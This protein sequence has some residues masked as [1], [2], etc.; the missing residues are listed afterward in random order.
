[1]SAKLSFYPVGN[2]DMALITLDNGQNILIDVNIRAA[3]DGEDEDVHDVAQDLKDRLP[4]DDDDRP[5]VD[6]FLISHP[7]VDHVSGLRNHFHLGPPDEYPDDDGEDRILIREMWSSPIIFRRASS[8]H[9]LGDD[10]KAWA[11]EAR[12]RVALFR[13]EGL[14]GTGDGDRIL[15]LGKDRDG[16]TDGI[17]EIVKLQDELVTA[18]NREEAGQF[19]ARLLAPIYVDPDQEDADKLIELLSKNNSSVI[20]RFSINA[21]GKKDACRFLSGGDAGVEIWDRLWRRHKGKNEDWFSYDVMETPHHCSWRT[22]SHDRWSE[23][24]EDVKVSKDARNALSQTRDGAHIVAS[25]NPIKKEEPNP[26]HERAKREYVS[27][28]AS[29]RFTCT[30]EYWEK[31]SRPIEFSI[32]HAGPAFSHRV[33][34]KKVAATIGISA[35]PTVARGHGARGRR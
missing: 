12:R 8:Q 20:L 27:M 25:C 15:I 18:A 19:E 14:E 24:G 10:A 28:T 7:D 30:E 9:K 13:K 16:K 26:P 4:R 23:M 1:M 31:H 3:A 29:D 21:D 33:A 22:L 32:T 11:K 34:A 6:A 17:M 2:G 35:I 5:Y